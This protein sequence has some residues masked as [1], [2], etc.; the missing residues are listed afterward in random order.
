MV[1]LIWVVLF[2]ENLCQKCVKSVMSAFEIETMENENKKRKR[3][4]NFMESEKENLIEII[5][6]NIKI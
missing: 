4:K 6:D 2:Y 3:C 1:K 5:C